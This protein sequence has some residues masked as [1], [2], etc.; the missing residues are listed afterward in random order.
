MLRC[1]TSVSSISDSLYSA[2]SMV[3]IT[4]TIGQTNDQACYSNLTEKP[5][6]YK[7]FQKK[8]KKLQFFKKAT[9]FRLFKKFYF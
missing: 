9:N 5:K 7:I 6:T 8:K 1:Q 3:I 2:L 4:T